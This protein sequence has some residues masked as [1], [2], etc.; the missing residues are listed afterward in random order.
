[1]KRKQNLGAE[2]EDPSGFRLSNKALLAISL[3]HDRVTPYGRW[4]PLRGGS[5][6]SDIQQRQRLGTTNNNSI[7]LSTSFMCCCFFTLTT[8]DILLGCGLSLGGSCVGAWDKLIP[9]APCVIPMSVGAD[10]E[11]SA[12]VR[13]ILTYWLTRLHHGHNI[14]CLLQETQTKPKDKWNINHLLC[15]TKSRSGSFLLS[16]GL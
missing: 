3:Q 12:D 1:M 14:I 13:L 2:N 15:E 7:T 16:E 6:H 9:E 8:T 4:T 10:P 5:Y 11:P